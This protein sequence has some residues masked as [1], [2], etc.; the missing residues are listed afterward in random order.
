M[1]SLGVGSGAVIRHVLSP[2]QHCGSRR[3]GLCAVAGEPQALAALE[4]VRAGTRILEAGTVIYS[5]GDRPDRIYNLVSGWIV[6]AQ[7][8]PDG[9]RSLPRFVLPGEIFG[10]EPRDRLCHSATTLTTASVC[11]FEK[12]QHDEVRLHHRSLNEH[13]LWLLERESFLAFETLSVVATRSAQTRLANLLWGL[14]VRALHR[15]P[16]VEDRIFLPLSQVDLAWGVGLTP[17]HVNR[18]LRQFREERLLTFHDHGLVV[19]DP[20]RLEALSGASEDFVAL[21]AED[22]GPVWTAR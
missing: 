8:R 18:V 17:V 14:A 10:I 12:A 2:C 19:A 16:R 22:V 15:R 4:R 20:K 9:R 7:D 11:V 13:F 5:Q 21:W 3:S 1:A 6:L